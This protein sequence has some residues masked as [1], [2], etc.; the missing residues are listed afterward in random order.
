M[1][2]WYKPIK[3]GLIPFFF[4]L[5][6]SISI[7]AAPSQ[8]LQDVTGEGYEL[9]IADLDVL[10]TNTKYEF[11]VHVYNGSNG[12]PIVEDTTCYLFVYNS[13][14]DQIATTQTNNVNNQFNYNLSL[15][16]TTF[17]QEGK[18]PYVFQ[19]NNSKQGGF[20]SG[21]YIVNTE[22]VLYDDDSLSDNYKNT[23]FM[24]VLI[25]LF[26]LFLILAIWTQDQTLASITSMF[27][28]VIGVFV[29]TNGF[30]GINNMVTQATAIIFIALGAYILLKVNME[31][32]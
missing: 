20:I 32:F 31:N 19:C 18:Y 22:G 28:I 21:N 16:A 10:K 29:A 11:G 6:F 12:R 14:L 5:L 7:Y 30:Y 23:T 4:I 2:D 25:G 26:V 9:Q 8:T 15:P 1:Q 27:M 13:S 17:N 3:K 24:Y